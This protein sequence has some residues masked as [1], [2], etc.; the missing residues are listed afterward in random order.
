[1]IFRMTV[2]LWFVCQ[3]L[4]QMCVKSNLCLCLNF[5]ILPL[6]VYLLASQVE[7]RLNTDS[8][9]SSSDLGG[10][11]VLPGLID[12]IEHGTYSYHEPT[13]VQF[14]AENLLPSCSVEH[15]SAKGKQ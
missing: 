9:S 1:M 13:A 5:H 15:A 11:Y 14:M 8:K 12:A 7:P 4:S 10:G 2:L 6:S 3:W